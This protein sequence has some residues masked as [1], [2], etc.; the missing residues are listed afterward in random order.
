MSYALEIGL[1]YLRSKK[2]KTVSVIT[3]IAVGGVMLGV[4]ALLSVVAITNGMQSEFRDKVLGVN[5]HVLVMKYGLDFEE[6]EDVMARALEM[7]EVA[8][9]AP[10]V[11]NEMMLTKGDRIAGVLVKGIDPVAMPTVL[12]LP[13]QLIA[14]SL[15]GLR[16]PLARAPARV[17]VERE[18]RPGEVDLD[19]YLRRVA[20]GATLEEA[21]TAARSEVPEAP[22]GQAPVPEGVVDELPAVVVP[23]PEQAEAALAA[24]GADEGAGDMPDELIEEGR[25]QAVPTDDLPGIVV[26]TT[27][28]RSL[29]I[30]VGDR[31]SVISPLSGLDTSAY[32]AEAKVPRSRDFRVIGVFAAGFQEYDT[33]L[34]YTD[35]F[36]AESF[37]D[38]GDSVTGVELRLRDIDEA[39]MIARRIERALGGGPYH[40]LD[41]QELNRNLFTALEIQKI[42]LSLV[43]ATIVFVAA[44]NVVGTLIMMVIE[45]RKEI[46]ILKAMGARDSDILVIFLVQGA[47]IGLLGTALGVLVGAA[48]CGYLEAVRIPLDPRVY[49]IDHVPVRIGPW[50][51][52]STV[53][54]ALGICLTATI[55]PSW[56]AAR[57]LP[58]D[59]VRYE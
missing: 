34:V 54:V 21:D 49:L 42:M 51:F 45:K 8:G 47:T 52:G 14:G 32:R 38:H 12:D 5:A 22:S 29:G 58:A 23:T 33:R 25:A 48:V 27:L 56:W 4:A 1:R 44:F 37:F 40:T 3:F 15:E 36:E 59:G 26:G 35:L 57:L 39:P 28:A 55:L 24:R 13:N 6:Y 30:V 41:W 16:L 7:P 46:A 50:E 31:V 18:R 10:F 17:E 20:E 53:A 19:V 9:A 43:I 2:Q 11:I